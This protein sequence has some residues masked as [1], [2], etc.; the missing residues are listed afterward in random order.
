MNDITPKQI[1]NRLSKVYDRSY[2][3]P[4]HKIEDEFVYKF[5]AENG[6]AEGKILDIGSGT[7]VL[8]NHIG[9]KPDNYVGLDISEK[10]LEISS[11]KFPNHKFVKGT[12]S[13]MPFDDESFDCVISLFGSFSYSLNHL[14]TLQE[15][16][17]VLKPNGKFL[18]M[19]YGTKYQNRE[20]Y[21]LNLFKISSPATFFKRKE[22]KD[23]FQ[24]FCKVRIFGMTWLSELVSKHFSYTLAKNYHFLE[25]K[26]LGSIIPNKFYFQIITGQKN[27]KTLLH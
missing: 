15:I 24:D 6:F 14:K 13:N 1:Y 11:S 8:L 18:I 19:A 17:R 20:S 5:L 3:E 26:F 25:T 10:M 23:L 12:M 27:A 16:K 4:I 2:K 9:I 22:L 21:I 7:G